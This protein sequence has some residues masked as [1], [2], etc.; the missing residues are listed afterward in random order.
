MKSL[1]PFHLAFP[2][3][4]IAA[5]REFYTMVLQCAVGRE[6]ERWIDFNFFG[7]QITAHLDA[8]V[9][10]LFGRN[11]V[12]NKA[13]PA[14]HFGAI[15]PWDEWDNMVARV[16][17]FNISYYVEPYTRFVGEI[18]EQRTFFIQDPSG[19]YLEFKCFK[20]PETTFKS[21]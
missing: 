13:I 11:Q 18:G 12:D 20:N 8:T 4:D 2:V 10:D 14:R 21:Q 5:A 9:V 17:Q 6:A 1:P 15:L 16:D 3:H 19:N 7:H